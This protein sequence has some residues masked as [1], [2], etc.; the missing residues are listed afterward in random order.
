MTCMRNGKKRS[1]S[2]GSS[3]IL[4]LLQQKRFRSALVLLYQKM[5]DFGLDKMFPRPFGPRSLHSTFFRPRFSFIQKGKKRQVKKESS[6]VCVLKRSSLLVQKQITII[7]DEL[8]SS[9][10]LRFKDRSMFRVE[11]KED[12]Q[13][14]NK[15]NGNEKGP[16][17]S[18]YVDTSA[19]DPALTHLDELFCCCV[20]WD[21]FHSNDSYIHIRQMPLSYISPNIIESGGFFTSFY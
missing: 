2:R 19:G 4:Y 21:I 6:S 1:S 5:D 13:Q 9:F 3:T 17:V 20:I 15:S 18:L 8:S 16:Q 7:V 11:A 14:N 12:E 10:A